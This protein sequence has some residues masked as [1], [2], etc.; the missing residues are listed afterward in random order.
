MHGFSKVMLCLRLQRIIPS[1]SLKGFSA[2]MKNMVRDNWR[3][4]I[5][6]IRADEMC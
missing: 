1:I 5:I 3:E 4:V 2:L 6:S